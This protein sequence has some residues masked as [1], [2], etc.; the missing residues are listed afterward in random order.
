MESEIYSEGRESVPILV[1]I[2]CSLILI[3]LE[4][5]CQKI[6]SIES[7]L[8]REIDYTI[9]KQLENLQIEREKQLQS[10]KMKKE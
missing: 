1:S 10:Y 6:T 3:S 8:E 4:E 9:N 5:V 7:L 2:L